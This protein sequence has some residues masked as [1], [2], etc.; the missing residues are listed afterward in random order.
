MESGSI[1][2]EFKM[3]KRFEVEF[4]PTAAKFMNNLD[5]K[6]QKKIYFN[7]RKAQVMNDPELL[8]N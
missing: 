5:A 6:A 1:E 3:E 8:K 2:E 4:L 7:I